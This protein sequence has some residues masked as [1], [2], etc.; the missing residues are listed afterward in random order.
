MLAVANIG[1]FSY[2][3]SA[4]GGSSTILTSSSAR[5]RISGWT[6]SGGPAFFD[7]FVGEAGRA[8]VGC[9]NK[10]AIYSPFIVCSILA[11]KCNQN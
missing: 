6:R 3:P 7:A 8:L 4:L 5:L 2:A 10:F 11:K 9:V 1:G